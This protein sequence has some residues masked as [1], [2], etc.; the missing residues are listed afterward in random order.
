MGIPLPAAT[1]WDLVQQS[2]V[3]LLPVYLEVI[4]QAAQGTILHNDD[5]T[6]KILEIEREIRQESAQEPGGRTGMFTTGIVAI[7][8]GYKIALFSTGR[9]PSSS[10]PKTAPVSVTFS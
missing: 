2:S 7:E 9:M 4:R 3:P 1:Q 10:R 8:S 6:I 5:T